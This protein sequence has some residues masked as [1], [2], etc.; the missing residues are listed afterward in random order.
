[1]ILVFLAIII[2]IGGYISEKLNLTIDELFSYGISIL[3]S[4]FFIGGFLLFIWDWA[5]SFRLSRNP[6]FVKDYEGLWGIIVFG[7]LLIAFII[8]IFK[9]FK[10]FIIWI[11]GKTNDLLNKNLIKTKTPLR[12]SLPKS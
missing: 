11:S 9:T 12:T 6:G 8:T 2:F 1:L 10:W 7:F 5:T 4:L 3:I